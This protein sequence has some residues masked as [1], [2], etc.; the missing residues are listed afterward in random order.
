MTY[1]IFNSVKD[2]LKADNLLKG[3]S[4]EGGFYPS[5]LDQFKI[6]EYL[7]KN[8][9]KCGYVPGVDVSISIDVAA[10]EIYEDNKYSIHGKKYTA[11]ELLSIY[12]DLN[13]NYFVHLIE[14]P[15]E[16]F[17]FENFTKFTEN[18]N[19][20]LKIISDDLTCTNLDLLKKA[21]KKNSLDGL[22]IKPNQCGTVSETI[23]V[24]NYC[25]EKNITTILSAR[26]GDTEEDYL[27][28]L[29]V[30][31]NVDMI[32]VGSFTRSERMS[33]WNELIRIKE[34]I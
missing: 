16:Q 6:C 21:Y 34:K 12:K 28:H 14:D 15:F 20:N 26:S 29:A 22:I 33:K 4:D 32:K 24:I 7:I 19:K 9:E 23:N 10:T 27:S 31:W 11:E 2:D 17:D 18:K 8:I 25:K 13:N 30:G 1:N 3:Y 5:S